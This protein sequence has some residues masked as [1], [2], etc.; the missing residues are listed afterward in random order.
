MVKEVAK[1]FAIQG[2]SY[3]A[4]MG[5]VYLLGK[6]F[7]FLVKD[8]R[9]F[10]KKG[11]IVYEVGKGAAGKLEKVAAREA[12]GASELASQKALA[13]RMYH[14]WAKY[15]GGAEKQDLVPLEKW[16]H[17]AYHRGLN[18]ILARRKGT[19]YYESLTGAAR[20]AMYRDLAKYTKEFDAKFGTKI[21]EAM[22]KEGFPGR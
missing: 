3:A 22:L 19:K 17:D 13:E 14:G 7:K 2:I 6:G 20:E 18:V 1:E 11:E 12:A 8:G 15:L 21:Y 10:L 4:G 9:Y 16:L 5:V